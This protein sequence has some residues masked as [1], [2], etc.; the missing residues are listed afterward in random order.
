MNVP[1]CAYGLFLEDA[2]NIVLNIRIYLVHEDKNEKT[3]V[4]MHIIMSIASC[5]SKSIIQTLCANGKVP[6]LFGVGRGHASGE[7]D[8]FIR[9]VSYIVLKSVKCVVIIFIIKIFKR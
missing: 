4:I 2:G 8:M 6:P 7:S 1:S 9:F 5:T 3:G